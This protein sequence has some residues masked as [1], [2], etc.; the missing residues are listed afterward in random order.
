MMKKY[1]AD[2]S[3]TVPNYYAGCVVNDGYLA[4]TVNLK[5]MRDDYLKNYL[6]DFLEK[7][8]FYFNS[9]TNQ[10]YYRD[11]KI[12]KIFINDDGLLWQT[13]R[14]I[15][16]DQ[17][18]FS[19]KRYMF[20]F[21][22]NAHRADLAYAML[23]LA[24]TCNK[25]QIICQRLYDP[26]LWYWVESKD[27]CGVYF[28]GAPWMYMVDDYAVADARAK[29]MIYVQ[30]HEIETSLPRFDHSNNYEQ[31]I[32]YAIC[33]LC[34]QFKKYGSSEFAYDPI[35]YVTNTDAQLLWNIRGKD[36]DGTAL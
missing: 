1:S 15:G 25:M 4:F 18:S 23:T 34:G 35:E 8:T 19:I 31:V 22:D 10:G 33:L 29:A 20:R 11:E 28:S 12:N 24:E 3:R 7:S 26:E 32:C 16:V 30:E 13:K 27:Y 9:L 6:G 36:V 17:G 14:F 21:D 2:L 5:M